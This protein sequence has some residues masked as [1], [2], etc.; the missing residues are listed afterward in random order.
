MQQYLNLIE[1]VLSE[2][3]P[4]SDPQQMG[5]LATL[6]QT[7]RFNLQDGFPL[8]TTRSFKS[9]FKPLC[10]ELLWFLSGSTNLADLK[11][12]YP[13]KIWD[14]W[15]DEKTSNLVSPPLPVGELGRIYGAQWR[16]FNAGL[17]STPEQI[18]RLIADTITPDW[19]KDDIAHLIEQHLIE[20]ARPVDQIKVLV[21]ELRRNPDSR[22]LVVTAWNP[23]DSDR[24]FI[25][26]CHCFFKFFH[27]QGE[28]SVDVFQRSADAVVGLPFDI[29]E[30]AL[31][32][33]MVAQVTGLRA[34]EV[35]YHTSDTHIYLPHVPFAKE[36]LSREPR[37]L[38][39]VTLNPEIT[40]LFAFKLEDFSLEG[41]DPHPL[42][43]G[44]PV[45]Y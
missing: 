29:A 15:A 19:T 32:L 6:G 5:N 18:A 36:I 1:R 31:L 34:R 27:A 45:G 24:V 41:Y 26:P 22:R 11:A 3:K 21:E 40:N 43:K 35:V 9:S 12:I 39:T 25:A 16:S 20:V 28:L 10:A 2:G 4:K 17:R 37:P 7:M 44:I 8:S 23:L 33:L 42:I 14:Q 38:P 30:Y 13:T